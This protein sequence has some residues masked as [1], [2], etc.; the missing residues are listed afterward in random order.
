MRK[1]ERKNKG[2]EKRTTGGKFPKGPSWYAHRVV[3]RGT[4]KM[5]GK[6]TKRT[7]K[8]GKKHK[9]FTQRRRKEES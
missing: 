8:R 2:N 6:C 1:P 5:G 9:T 7:K 3:G 4:G